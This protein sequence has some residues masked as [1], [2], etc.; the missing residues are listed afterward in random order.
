MIIAS[1][2]P[3]SAMTRLTQRWFSICLAASSFILSP[4]AMEPVKE[5][6]RVLASSTR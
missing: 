6:K 3:I 1:L 5:M 4:V 2:P